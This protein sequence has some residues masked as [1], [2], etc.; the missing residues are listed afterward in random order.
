ML[1]LWSLVPAAPSS[2]DFTPTGVLGGRLAGPH[3][4]KSEYVLGASLSAAV[5]SPYGRGSCTSYRG[6]MPPVGSKI[7][8]W[9]CRAGWA[10]QCDPQWLVGR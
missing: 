10:V 4:L 1:H 5:R 8:N 2:A 3:D 9:S 6:G 7:F